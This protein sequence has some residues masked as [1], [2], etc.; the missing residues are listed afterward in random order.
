MSNKKT[1]GVKI[2]M[3]SKF[4]ASVSLQDKEMKGPHNLDPPLLVT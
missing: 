2:E 3:G 1:Q 4:I